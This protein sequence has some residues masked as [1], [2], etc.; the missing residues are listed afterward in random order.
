MAKTRRDPKGRALQKGESYIAGR[1]MYCFTYMDPMRVRR[2]VYSK[3]LIDLRE[4]EQNIRRDSLDGIDSY[5]SSNC[6]VDYLFERYIKTK[7]EL[8]SS[9]RSNYIYTY[10]HYVKRLLGTRKIGELKY[11]DFKF[12]FSR[13]LDRGL[14]LNTV[15]GMNRILVSMFG[16]AVRD[17]VIRKNPLDGAFTEIKKSVKERPVRHALSY[18]EEKEFLDYLDQP[19]Y[20][21]WRP[22][23]I[24]MFGTG[25]RIGET[26]G[27]RWEDIDFDTD[28]IEVNHDITYCP[29]EKHDFRCEYEVGP[30]K[31]IA[32]IR[33]IPL[34]SKVKDALTE[35]KSN[36]DKYGIHNISVVDGMSG[37]VFCNRFGELHKPSSINRAIARIVDDHNAGE[38]VKAA[39]EGRD[40]VMIP[41]FSCHVTR[42]TFCSR[43]CENGTNIKLIQQIMG[44]SDIRT[45]M[46]IYA[47]VSKGMAHAVFQELNEEDV[48]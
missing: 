14:S 47:E 42:H 40:P 32:G 28:E 29:R 27:I 7:K 22:L 20:D 19:K 33:T 18:E 12:F 44:H 3:N 1:K 11:S 2:Y 45:T 41:R 43:L 25:C 21:R 6:T 26:I 46:D 5:A 24:F 13:Q 4:K 34:M 30:P 37:F 39:K 38:E 31:T 23:F 8:R 36:Q 35:E 10:N 9:T 17:D 16:L 15:S 48:L